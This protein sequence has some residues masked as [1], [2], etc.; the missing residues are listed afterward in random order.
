MICILVLLNV[1]I[2]MIPS[3]V[4]ELPPRMNQ[5][6]GGPL[7]LFKCLA[8]FLFS[9]AHSSEKGFKIRVQVHTLIDLRGFS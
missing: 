5:T 6:C 4:R 7:I 1:Q 2:G 8:D 3:S 9:Q